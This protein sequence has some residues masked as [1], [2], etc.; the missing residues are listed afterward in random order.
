MF[1]SSFDDEVISARL[2]TQAHA[3]GTCSLQYSYTGPT[4][5]SAKEIIN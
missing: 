2:L 1:L 3:L 4:V 5:A